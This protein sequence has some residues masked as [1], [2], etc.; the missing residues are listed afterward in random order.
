MGVALYVEGKFNFEL[1]NN[2]ITAY[3]F[4][5][6]V[7][8]SLYAKS[9]D[10]SQFLEIRGD[11]LR[12]AT[13]SMESMEAI[14]AWS[15]W[16][17][18]DRDSYY[19]NVKVVFTYRDEVMR[20]VTFPDAHIIKY[21]EE[22]NPSSGEGMYTMLIGQKLDKRLD[23]VIDPF[24]VQWPIFSEFMRQREEKQAPP[25]I[26]DDNEEQWNSPYWIRYDNVVRPHVVANR[27]IALMAD[28]YDDISLPVMIPQG[29]VLNV[30]AANIVSN[31]IRYSVAHDGKFGWVDGGSWPQDRHSGTSGVSELVN[32]MGERNNWRWLVVIRRNT[33]GVALIFH[34]GVPGTDREPEQFTHEDFVYHG[35]LEGTREAETLGRSRGLIHGAWV[36]LETPVT[37][38]LKGISLK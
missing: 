7:E 22:I 28:G 23:V 34:R 8:N 35:L 19:H 16:K 5:Y 11:V 17:F 24:N 15:K 12:T 31:R 6:A 27:D 2:E 10:S 26:V 25:A 13:V 30:I 29:R 4:K 21:Q 33:T 32:N 1:V 14:R 38:G 3:E 9:S 36:Q 18:K 20:E 37:L